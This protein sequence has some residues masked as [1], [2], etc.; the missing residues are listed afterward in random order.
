MQT[1]TAKSEK[2]IKELKDAIMTTLPIETKHV[3]TISGLE[4]AENQFLPLDEHPFDHFLI[5]A[6]VGEKR[7]WLSSKRIA[8]LL[9]VIELLILFYF[10]F[11]FSKILNYKIS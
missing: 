9:L 3:F 1:Q 5:F 7:K 4:P 2:L 10:I 11:I 8:L 6:V